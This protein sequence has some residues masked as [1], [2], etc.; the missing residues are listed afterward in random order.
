MIGDAVFLGGLGRKCGCKL[1]WCK[2]FVVWRRV[3]YWGGDMTVMP[4]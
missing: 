3:A 2:G 4:E 1:L